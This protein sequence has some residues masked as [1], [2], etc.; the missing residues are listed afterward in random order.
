M[1][2]ECAFG[3]LEAHW[4]ALIRCLVVEIVNMSC[5]IITAFILHD[6]CETR[7]HVASAKPEQERDSKQTRHSALSMCSTGRLGRA[8]SSLMLGIPI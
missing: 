6:L 4:Q 7:R 2:V 5:L 3:L 8:S 1:T